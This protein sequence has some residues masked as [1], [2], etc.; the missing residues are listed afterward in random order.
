MTTY[1]CRI[2]RND[3]GS[4]LFSNGKAIC[5]K[6]WWDPSNREVVKASRLEPNEITLEGAASEAMRK[7]CT[8]C[9]HIGS[10][11]LAEIEKK[12]PVYGMFGV[13]VVCLLLGGMIG[14]IGLVGGNYGLAGI[15]AMAALIFLPMTLWFG[16][17]ALG[18]AGS[19]ANSKR[20]DACPK[21]G[22]VDSL[23]PMDSPT[24][25][26]LTATSIASSIA[27]P[28]SLPEAVA[29]GKPTKDCPFCAETIKRAAIV[30]RYC[31]KDLPANQEVLP[32]S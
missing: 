7:V 2:C 3:Y 4:E 14:G 6:C 8:K 21:C 16:V 18:I 28:D 15:G 30:C 12:N 13:S 32:Q 26:A 22:A 11:T 5:N 31:G 20:V 19:N 1:Q 23:I 25:L 17:G 27:Q 24:A 29:D 10:P 9:G